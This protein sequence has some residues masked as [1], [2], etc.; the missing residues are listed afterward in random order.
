MNDINI[1]GNL[2]MD[3]TAVTTTGRQLYGQYDNG[4]SYYTNSIAVDRSYINKD[5]E[6]VKRAEFIDIKAF[7]KTADFIFNY[8][9]KGDHIIVNGELRSVPYITKEGNKRNSVYVEV[10]KVEKADW[11]KWREKTKNIPADPLS[12]GLPFE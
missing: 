11:S 12:E 8:F 10:K 6:R 4:T 3:P 1:T 7:G 2:V 5:G 9:Q